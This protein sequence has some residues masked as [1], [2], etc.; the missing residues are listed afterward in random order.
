MS[1][2][3]YVSASFPCP[4]CSKKADCRVNHDGMVFCHTHR[5]NY[6]QHDNHVYCG[7]SCNIWGMWLPEHLAND[8]DRQRGNYSRSSRPSAPVRPTVSA[9][10]VRASMYERLRRESLPC[11]PMH[12]EMLSSHLG[13]P[14]S[15][16][17]HMGF[18]EDHQSGIS[19]TPWGW[20]L[21][22][23]G[24]DDKGE[25]RP[26]CW[27]I[28]YGD[29]TKRNHGD[30]RIENSPKRG[31][32]LLDDYDQGGIVYVPEGA[33]CC[34]AL[35]AMGL[36]AIGRPSSRQGAETLARHI[37]LTPAFDDRPII[38]I[39]ENDL[40]QKPGELPRWEGR[41]G[42]R[43]VAQQLADRLGRVVRVGYVPGGVKDVRDWFWQYWH[44]E[45]DE[46]AG[47]AERFKDG[48]CRLIEIYEP[49][50]KPAQPV[51]PP[52][53]PEFANL[54]K[55]DPSSFQLKSRTKH[56]PVE[57]PVSYVLGKPITGAPVE[58][59]VGR[60]FANTVARTAGAVLP[61]TPDQ[62]ERVLAH[63][64]A[65]YSTRQ[66]RLDKL[67]EGMRAG[68]REAVL[69]GVDVLGVLREQE[70]RAVLPI[71]P[72]V[73]EEEARRRDEEER[74]RV[75]LC[76]A[77]T[78][79]SAEL[80]QW[81]AEGWAAKPLR[82]LGCGNGQTGI[83]TGKG[84]CSI[85]TGCG[86]N[87]CARC[88]WAKRAKAAR[89][90][91]DACLR[92]VAEVGVPRRHPGKG[93]EL[94][95]ETVALPL[96]E[97]T[98]S[99]IVL[100]DRR[101]V[102]ALRKRVRDRLAPAQGITNPGCH[103]VLMDSG[104]YAYFSEVNIPGAQQLSPA[105]AAHYA[106]QAILETPCQGH[107]WRALGKWKQARKDAEHTILPIRVCRNEAVSILTNAGAEVTIHGPPTLTGGDPGDT[108]VNFSWEW[109]EGIDPDTIEKAYLD[110][111]DDLEFAALGDLPSVLHFRPAC[112]PLSQG[113]AVVD[114]DD[115]FAWV[116]AIGAAS[117]P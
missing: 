11:N 5:H 44:E 43:I 91:S 1:A 112:A 7:E 22:E 34:L 98:I 40:K 38:I 70:R 18:W 76:E 115:P 117:G 89:N 17:D 45:G 102:A 110:L 3:R 31:L 59:P 62:I 55:L 85:K 57:P 53:A 108:H 79:A 69:R 114:D 49:N 39:A 92:Q 90:A 66:E 19:P 8:P 20:T 26:V 2:F 72:Y 54:P 87:D 25:F 83:L 28:R 24:F 109:P 86:C 99:H 106:A 10:N 41:D 84:G 42:A 63:L 12:A 74:R 13:L 36:T 32:T 78:H 94:P 33:T 47:M 61:L 75:R 100:P 14:A 73:S 64:A 21:P 77:A 56:Q 96:R 60:P 37:A 116:D 105:E 95:P 113:V 35:N 29:G 23:Y 51:A 48:I 4:L 107:A 27:M 104:Q 88:S 16:A 67:A 15:C 111:E 101:A 82:K 80:E 68:D 71:V 103:W 97:G 52:V 46:V 30:I 81:I 93:K 65:R 50:A 9:E 6:G 58:Q